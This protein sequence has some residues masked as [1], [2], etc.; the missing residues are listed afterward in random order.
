MCQ[1]VSIPFPFLIW[2]SP[3]KYEHFILNSSAVT[4]S[5]C[6]EHSHKCTSL[7]EKTWLFMGMLLCVNSGFCSPSALS[8][9]NEMKYFPVMCCKRIDVNK[10]I[11][12]RQNSTYL[13]SW[14]YLDYRIKI[15]SDKVLITRRIKTEGQVWYSV[16]W[17]V[18]NRVHGYNTTTGEQVISSKV[19]T[20][21]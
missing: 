18:N 1:I 3:K 13:Y 10:C 11:F 15:H 20:D 19:L 16:S 5:G 2:K 7:C 12:Q 14:I 21:Y 17:Q 4:F 9:S 6:T 8:F